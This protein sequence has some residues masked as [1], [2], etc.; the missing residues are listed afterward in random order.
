MELENNII[1]SKYLLSLDFKHDNKGE[2]LFFSKYLVYDLND[3]DNPKFK[4]HD[5]DDPESHAKKINA[6]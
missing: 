3:L 2:K 5:I 1:D 6:K 4:A